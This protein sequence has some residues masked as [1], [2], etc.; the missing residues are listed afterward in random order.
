MWVCMEN[1]G[2][3][4]I[5]VTC[6]LPD[7]DT[8]VSGSCIAAFLCLYYGSEVQLWLEVIVERMD[9]FES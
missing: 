3:L 1:V 7:V 2:R 5:L 9:S 4:F 6:S 8:I